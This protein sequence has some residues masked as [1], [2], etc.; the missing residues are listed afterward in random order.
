LQAVGQQRQFFPVY[1]AEDFG[2]E[3]GIFK[4]LRPEQVLLA[5]HGP[6]LAGALAGWDQHDFRQTVVCGYGGALRWARRP[7][8]AWAR[9]RSLPT[10]PAPGEELRYLTAALPVAED[11]APFAALLG[12]LLE[13]SAGGPAGYLL[14]GLHEDD[15]LLG[16]VRPYRPR[17]YTTRLYLVCWEDGE[18]VRKGLG[19]RPPYLELGCL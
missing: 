1:R 3:G 14:L 5:F 6:R 13:R 4:G 8:N 9:W 19:A 16:V 10:L 15:P 11:A 17:W 2:T 7:Y 18:G 12:A